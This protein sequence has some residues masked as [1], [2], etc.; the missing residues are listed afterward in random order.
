MVSQSI[1]QCPE[2]S[3]KYYPEGLFAKAMIL[4]G[5]VRRERDKRVV[6]DH[7]GDQK[8]KQDRNGNGADNDRSF[9]IVAWRILSPSERHIHCKATQVK[10]KPADRSGLAVGMA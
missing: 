8:D 9:R 1:A 7:I 5:C 6:D 3:D 10:E 4:A 2:K